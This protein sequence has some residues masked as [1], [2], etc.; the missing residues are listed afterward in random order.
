M[1]W[2]SVKIYTTTEGIE[3]LCGRLYL[4]GAGGVQIEDASDF[5]EFIETNTPHWDYIDESLEHLKNCETSVTVYLTD[6]EAG[7]AQLSLLREGVSAMKAAD[8]GGIYGSLRIEVEGRDDSEWVDNWKRYYK[9]FTVGERTLVRPEWESVEDTGGR[10]VL[11]MDPG[12]LFGSGTHSSTRM[13]LGQIDKLIRGGE[14]VLDIGCGSGI[15]A[16]L[17]LLLGA[18]R[19]LCIDIDAGAPRVVSDNAALN[20]IAP[21]RYSVMVGNCLDESTLPEKIDDDFDI[22]IANIVADVI[23]GLAGSAAG[24]V[25]AGGKFI[26]SGIIEEREGAVLDALK[27]AGFTLLD[28][29]HD[30]GWSCLVCEK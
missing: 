27:A 6:D 29:V 2:L 12:H 7:M 15:L 26:C 21:G 20:G 18:E 11:T 14:K 19:A 22:V 28:T 5:N 9:P 3:P 30:G 24:Y 25:R 1:K 23:I 13:C 10:T 16:I 8:T 4:L 17:A